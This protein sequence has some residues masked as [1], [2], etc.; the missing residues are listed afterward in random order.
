MH[1][2][3][4]KNAHGTPILDVRA[5]VKNW[6]KENPGGEIHIGC[7][8]KRRGGNIKYSVSICMYYVG[9]GVHEIYTT[10]T[11]LSSTDNFSRLW[12]EVER[13]VSLAEFLKEIG[14]IAVH[15]DLNHDN[16][17]LSSKLYEAS[18]G[19]IQSLGFKAIGKPY[20]WAASHGAH[21]HCQ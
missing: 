2:P 11:V 20:A 14:E 10:E 19:F 7:D 9:N 1:L 4:F 17:Y 21:Q 13:A 3:T 6:I 18:M 16:R 12:N 5:Y 15:V 8:S